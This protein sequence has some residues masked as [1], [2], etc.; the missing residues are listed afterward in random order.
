[1]SS[2]GDSTVTVLEV[3][4]ARGIA[5]DAVVSLCGT[6]GLRLADDWAGRPS[7]TVPDARALVSAWELRSVEADRAWRAHEADRDAWVA[8]RT[9]AVDAA[10]AKVEADAGRGR[11]SDGDM[12]GRQWAAGRHAAEQYERTYPR[13]RFNG[14]PTLPLGFVDES[15]EGSVVARVAAAVRGPKMPAGQE[16]H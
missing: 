6:L 2:T 3:A 4:A 16:V 7:L 11:I 9:A 10:R 8:A 1:M 15:Q 12:A 14:M 13:P 5:P